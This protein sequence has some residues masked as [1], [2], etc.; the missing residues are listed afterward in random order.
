MQSYFIHYNGGQKPLKENDQAFYMYG[1]RSDDY[2]LESYGFCL[3][4]N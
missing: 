3:E 2:L 4:P 1:S